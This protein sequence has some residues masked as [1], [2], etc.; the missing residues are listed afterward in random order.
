MSIYNCST[1]YKCM[2]SRQLNYRKYNIG[3]NQHLYVSIVKQQLLKIR[4]LYK[5]HTLSVFMFVGCY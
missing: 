5:N 4:V 2:Q 3:Q 1:V